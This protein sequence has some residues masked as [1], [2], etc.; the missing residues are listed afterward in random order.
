MGEA[1]VRGPSLMQ[2][3]LGDADPTSRMA[4]GGYFLTGDWIR[5]LPDGHVQVVGRKK[6]LIIR[7]G[8]NID[9]SEIEHLVRRRDDVLDCAVFGLP[10][11]RLG[12][13]V[14]L[15]VVPQPGAAPS[16]EVVLAE[17]RELGLSTQKLPQVFDIRDEFP[18]SPDGKVLKQEIREQVLATRTVGAAS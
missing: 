13:I 2:G 11:E 12:E 17:L 4:D 6:D 7:G 8:Y 14:C 1:G 16:A 5:V 10:D 9:P 15:S 18:L 3:Y